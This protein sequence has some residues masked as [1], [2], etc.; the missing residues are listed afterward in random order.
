MLGYTNDEMLMF[1][2][3]AFRPINITEQIKKFLN[4][5]IKQNRGTLD[6]AMDQLMKLI[7]RVS[8]MSIEEIVKITTDLFFRGPIDLTQK[9][10][11]KHNQNYSV[12]YY[13][14]SQQ[15]QYSM[16]RLN[17]NP[18][19]GTAHTDDI[20]YIFNV[21][22]LHA[23]T[24]PTDPFNQFRK[25]MV[26]LWANFAK[27]GYVTIQHCKEKENFVDQFV[28]YSINILLFPMALNN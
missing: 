20:G 24:D 9:L 2:G 15:T 7:D 27:Y 8:E 14:V 5:T 18:L 13:Q 21:E 6:K 28:E 19:N 10:L 16:H 26:E 25:K 12:Y 4:D 1:L 11:V 23:P 22:A 3:P 17:G